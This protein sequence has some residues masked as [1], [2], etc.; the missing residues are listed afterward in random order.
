MLPLGECAD[1]RDRRKRA[2]RLRD[3]FCSE[4]HLLV[5]E[6]QSLRF[7]HQD[8]RDFFAAVHILNESEIC[9]SK[10]EIPR[11]FKEHNEKGVR[12]KNTA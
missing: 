5:E 1:G 8:F 11:V 6:G 7:L 9:V 4:L 2:A 12:Q 10:G 3:I